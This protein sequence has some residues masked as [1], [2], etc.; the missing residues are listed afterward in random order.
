MHHNQFQESYI[1]STSRLGR[2][3]SVDNACVHG[4]KE[5]QLLMTGHPRSEAVMPCICQ[6]VLTTRLR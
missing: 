3:R 5:Y 6:L 4:Y 2:E 1:S